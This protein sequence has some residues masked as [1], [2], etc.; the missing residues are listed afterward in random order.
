MLDERGAVVQEIVA[1]GESGLERL[2]ELVGLTD[3][4]SVYLAI[5]AGVDPTPVEAI[6]DLKRRIAD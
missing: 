4:A 2:A 1:E 6:E 3:Y 5:L